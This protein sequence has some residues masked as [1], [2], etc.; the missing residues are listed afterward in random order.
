ML[1]VILNIFFDLSI[2]NH[3]PRD[4]QGLSLMTHNF[5]NF[6]FYSFIFSP[7]V[8]RFCLL[9][10]KIHYFV[11]IWLSKINASANI[12]FR[13]KLVYDLFFVSHIL[14]YYFFLHE[15]YLLRVLHFV[16]FNLFWVAGRLAAEVLYEGSMTM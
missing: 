5:V 11:T 14:C 1:I 13:T 12:L 9:C 16:G 10:I 6:I 3:H 7:H 4:I 2:C 8:V 15:M